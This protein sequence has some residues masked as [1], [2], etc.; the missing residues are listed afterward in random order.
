MEFEERKNRIRDYINSSEYI[1]LKRHELAIMLDV[2]AQD[3]QHF[4]DIIDALTAEGSAVETKKGKIMAAEKLNIYP[5]VFTG[6][7]KGFGFVR[8]EGME[9]DIFIP[10]DATNGAMN[11]DKVL[12][13]VKER[14]RRLQGRGRGA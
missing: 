9:N 4:N 14:A 6:N 7:A 12:I 10:S 3:M 13:K 1:P 11:K 5:G 8:V 2:P